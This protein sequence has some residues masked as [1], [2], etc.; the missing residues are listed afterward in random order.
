MGALAALPNP[1]FSMTVLPIL[2]LPLLI[3]AISVVV[4]I[5][6]LLSLR[7]ATVTTCRGCGE[8]L[9]GRP[10]LRICPTCNGDRRVA[11]SKRGVD[12]GRRLIRRRRRAVG[13]LVSLLLLC[14]VWIGLVVTY[15]EAGPRLDPYKPTGLLIHEA[16]ER[17]DE[18]DASGRI[19]DSNGALQE[20]RNRISRLSAADIQA[21]ADHALK[22]EQDS[23]FG[24]TL[25][26]DKWM[27]FIEAAHDQGH[28]L[29]AQWLRYVQQGAGQA[30][31]LLSLR[32]EVRRG[33]PLAMWVSCSPF[34][35][36]SRFDVSFEPDGPLV[37]GG[38]NVGML[39][40]YGPDTMFGLK[41]APLFGP[42][43]I[44]LPPDVLASLT[45]GPQTAELTATMKVRDRRDASGNPVYSR[46]IAMQGAWTLLPA[47]S[48]SLTIDAGIQ[49]KTLARMAAATKV[50]NIGGGYALRIS[51]K[52]DAWVQYPFACRI[53]LANNR[54]EWELGRCICRSGVIKETLRLPQ[55][56]TQLVTGFGR[57]PA[58]VDVI[59]RPCDEDAVRT[60]E[61]TRTWR[62]DIV[63]PDV[64]IY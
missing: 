10:K 3:M 60:I 56:T 58:E 29:S 39:E 9:W 4:L 52:Y 15:V 49:R 25:Y 54:G 42:R 23:R 53:Y 11:R 63:I 50:E 44:D 19:G 30:T 17:Q 21:V 57:F 59:I 20:L 32:Q 18:L 22:R 6:L 34:T 7:A 2:L 13:F 51:G 1:G 46:R 62:G 14:G 31:T 8:N 45:D 24:Q 26:D 61:C 64:S 33:D 27:G 41:A 12:G 43:L 47:S 16:V 48:S 35:E 28:L 55:R 37:I 36:V 5:R 38:H 40:K